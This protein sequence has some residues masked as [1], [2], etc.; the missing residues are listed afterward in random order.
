MVT[1]KE[2][3]TIDGNDIEGSVVVQPVEM[4]VNGSCS[5]YLN[6]SIRRVWGQTIIRQRVEMWRVGSTDD[7][8]RQS[9]EKYNN[10]ESGSEMTEF[11]TNR[12][13]LSREVR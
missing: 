6:L 1:K 5:L 12:G 2:D 7:N 8:C 13:K 10:N 3:K 11:Y 4:K 9:K